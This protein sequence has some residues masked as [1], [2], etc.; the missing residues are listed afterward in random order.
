M[1]IQDPILIK[2]KTFSQHKVKEVAILKMII[3]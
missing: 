1:G 3:P 2:T